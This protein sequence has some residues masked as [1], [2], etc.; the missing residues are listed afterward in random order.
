MT[1]SAAV[2]IVVPLALSN[3]CSAAAAAGL[4]ALIFVDF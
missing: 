3:A 4:V 1:V 2:V